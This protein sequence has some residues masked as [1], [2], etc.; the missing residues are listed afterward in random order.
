[1]ATEH[2]ALELG[3]PLCSTSTSRG[4]RR[5][6][7]S[8]ATW[9]LCW[10]GEDCKV[11][12]G[13]MCRGQMI[14]HLLAMLRSNRGDIEAPTRAVQPGHAK[15][16]TFFKKCLE[17]TAPTLLRVMIPTMACQGI[18][19]DIISCI[20]FGVV[21]FLFLCH[22]Q[23]SLK[24]TKRGSLILVAT[25]PWWG[26]SLGVSGRGSRK[27]RRRRSCSGTFAKLLLK[28]RDPHLQGGENKTPAAPRSMKAFHQKLH[29]GLHE[30]LAA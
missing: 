29:Q 23:K 19:S 27:V 3:V 28:S 21:I 11:A 16:T 20:L 7:D 24:Q 15:P 25:F 4:W 2:T 22:L 10:R 6:C 14:I 30:A 13:L 12:P 26:L 17:E 9:V 5:Q 1:M 18:H 8:P